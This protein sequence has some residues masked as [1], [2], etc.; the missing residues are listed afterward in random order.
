MKTQKS[1]DFLQPNWVCRECGHQWGLWWQEGQYRG[2]IRHCAT[3]HEGKCDV[4]GNK[5][6]VTEPRDYGYLKEGW[7][8]NLTDKTEII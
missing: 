7:H 6:S 8:E 5:K 4:C 1:L 3:L 2:P